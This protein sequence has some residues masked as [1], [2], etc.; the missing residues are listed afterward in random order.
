MTKDIRGGKVL[1]DWSQNNAAK[2]T[3]AVYSLRARPQ[4][5]VSIPI[6]WDEVESCSSPND[7][8]FTAADTLQRVATDGDRFSGLLDG[9]TAGRI[10]G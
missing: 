7:L 5:T 2:T 1:I 9:T 4:P 3:V 6:G 8:V 10:P